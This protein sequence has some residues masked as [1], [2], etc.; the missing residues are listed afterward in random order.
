M[1]AIIY[2][3]SF[4]V[5]A[6]T[7]NVGADVG[8]L[9]KA[10]TD[11]RLSYNAVLRSADSKPDFEKTFLTNYEQLESKLD[12]YQQAIAD[13]Y[14]QTKKDNKAA[15]AKSL[16]FSVQF[17]SLRLLEEL[18]KEKVNKQSC[19]RVLSRLEREFGSHKSFEK[20]IKEKIDK[21]CAKTN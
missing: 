21:L 15:E 2:L 14:S 1:R 20:M 3:F 6:L 9:N 17:E 10:E 18:A 12:L 16:E 8:A 11:Y 4:I 13:E 7:A 5:L 19:E